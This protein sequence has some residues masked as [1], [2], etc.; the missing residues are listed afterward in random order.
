MIRVVA[1]NS[2]NTMYRKISVLLAPNGNRRNPLLVDLI[3]FPRLD[4]SIER[5]Q[6]KFAVEDT[7]KRTKSVLGAKM[8]KRYDF[9]LYV[10]ALLR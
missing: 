7:L 10:A 8:R 5:N 4:V 9:P 1:G 6:T 2:V 3:S